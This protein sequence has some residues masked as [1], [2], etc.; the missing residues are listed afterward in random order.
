MPRAPTGKREPGA[1]GQGGSS[2]AYIVALLSFAGSATTPDVMR[3]IATFNCFPPIHISL[4]ICQ[5][6]VQSCL[7]SMT[8]S[9][10]GTTR[11]SPHFG[12]SVGVPCPWQTSAAVGY[13][14]VITELDASGSLWFNSSLVRHP[15]QALPRNDSRRTVPFNHGDPLTL[16]RASLIDR[17][18][19]PSTRYN[20]IASSNNP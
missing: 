5:H 15:Q 1:S 2:R 20:A 14:A 19:T 16:G 10:E 9:T 7:T 17:T 6:F 12:G 18:L 11:T 8:S 3:I 4:Q 13:C